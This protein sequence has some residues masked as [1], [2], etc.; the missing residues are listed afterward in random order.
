MKTLSTWDGENIRK[1]IG[2]SH[3][4]PID[5]PF[6]LNVSARMD[7]VTA[8]TEQDINSQVDTY[9]M[10]RERARQPPTEPQTMQEPRHPLKQ[11]IT[12]PLHAPPLRPLASTSSPVHM[13]PPASPL[14]RRQASRS[15]GAPP[16]QPPIPAP[17]LDLPS[18][19]AFLTIPSAGRDPPG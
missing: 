5:P 1:F 3:E 16:Q 2:V 13:N 19:P 18:A 17:P 6:T 9:A 7:G 4:G 12:V 8:L 14:L 15:S 10:M 11:A